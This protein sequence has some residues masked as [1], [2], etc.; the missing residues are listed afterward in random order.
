MKHIQVNCT[1]SLSCIVAQ[2]LSAPETAASD[3]IRF[4]AV[5][6]KPSGKH[7]RAMREIQPDLI[8]S[9]GSYCRIHEKPRKY[10]QKLQDIN[11]KSRILKEEEDFIV[12]DK[13][14]GVPCSPAVDNLYECVPECLKKV[15]F[16]V[17]THIE[18]GH[19]LPYLQVLH[20][21]DVDTSG[22]MVLGKTKEFTRAFNM[23]LARQIPHRVYRTLVAC[24]SQMRLPP[25]FTLVP[26]PGQTL[27]HLTMI[28]DRSPKAFILPQE[29]EREGSR[30]K[31]ASSQIL[32]YSPLISRTYDEWKPILDALGDGPW[33]KWLSAFSPNKGYLGFQQ[34][35]MKLLTGRTHQVRG[36]MHNLRHKDILVHVAGDENYPGPTSRSTASCCSSMQVM[37]NEEN[38]HHHL[39]DELALQS[40]EQSFHY[41]R[42]DYV[43]QLPQA[44]CSW[45]ALTQ[46]LKTFV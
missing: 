20:R 27:E 24:S 10:T 22:I 5:Y 7:I 18:K 19:Q 44:S 42:E 17:A 39:S 3:L 33:H 40:V 32:N 13:P 31:L 46:H 15:L 28:S 12:I 2:A 1:K 21:L 25:D 38:A 29:Q 45:N 23:Q 30:Y 9:A 26:Q 4:G 14:A 8:V 16:P 37:E 35:E 6:V 41:N 43:F 34:V 36:Q 11:W